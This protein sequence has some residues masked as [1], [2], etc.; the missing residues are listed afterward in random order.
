[1]A[2]TTKIHVSSVDNELYILATQKNL[3]TE[4]FHAKAGAGHLVDCVITPDWILP[5]GAYTLIL[6]GINWGGHQHF[7]VTLTTGGVDTI[8]TAPASTVVGANWTIAIPITV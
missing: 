1:M 5:P 6:I 3:S 2:T 7:K 4:L 8:H